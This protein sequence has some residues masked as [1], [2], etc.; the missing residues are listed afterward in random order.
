MGVSRSSLA[1]VDVLSIVAAT[2]VS[3]REWC[4]QTANG[5]GRSLI[6]HVVLV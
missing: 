5:I 4:L 2:V 1:V 6:M 3:I